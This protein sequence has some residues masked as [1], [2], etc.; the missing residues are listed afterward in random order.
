MLDLTLYF[1]VAMA[2]GVVFLP[3][4]LVLGRHKRGSSLVMAI[5]ISIAASAAVGIALGLW[6]LASLFSSQAVA[7]VASVGGALTFAGFAGAY[8]LVLPISVDRSLSAHVVGLVYSSPGGRLKR[9]EL[10]RL[11]SHEAILGKRMRECRDAHIVEW[12]GDDLVITPKGRRIARVYFALDWLMHTGAM[13]Q[14]T[15]L[16][17]PTRGREL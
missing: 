3:V 16:S 7:V 12:Q 2:S 14:S 17:A 10:L 9:S 13:I 8:A 6:P 5:A 15:D 4:H 11:Y 1:L